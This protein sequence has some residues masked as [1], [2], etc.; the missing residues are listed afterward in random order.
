MPCG[1]AHGMSNLHVCESTNNT[2][3]Y[4]QLLEQQTA[5]QRFFHGRSCLFHQDKAKPGSA[6]IIIV[7]LFS[8]ILW[9]LYWP[10]CSPDLS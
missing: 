5:K 6:C 4:I 3:R 10:V 7:W 2:E 9:V 1:S 8:K